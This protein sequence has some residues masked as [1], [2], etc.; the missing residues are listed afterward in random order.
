MI[1]EIVG[2]S[3]KPVVTG[4]VQEETIEI[5]DGHSVLGG[6]IGEA[7]SINDEVETE[8]SGGIPATA[9]P[10]PTATMVPTATKKPTATMK[11][12][13]P[14]KTPKT[15]TR[16]PIMFSPGAKFGPSVT[17]TPKAT[18]KFGRAPVVSSKA[19]KPAAAPSGPTKQKTTVGS[20]APT[21]RTFG[22]FFGLRSSSSKDDDKKT[23]TS[24][25]SSSRSRFS[26]VGRATGEDEA[27]SDGQGDMA[28]ESTGGS[29]SSAS[30]RE[31]VSVLAML[32]L[33]LV[34]VNRKRLGL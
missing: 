33:P 25:S 18:N 5:I 23:T 14:K 29:C 2:I 16:A 9:T 8:V 4:Q 34:I 1:E 13:P 19:S 31:G 11:P 28:E 26:L 27:Q 10:Q 21:R 7:I 6:L 20:K 32:M 12:V 30:G 3:D 22:N 24:R 17:P 15:N